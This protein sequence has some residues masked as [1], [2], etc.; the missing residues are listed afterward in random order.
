M[1]VV[2]SS[3][4]TTFLKSFNFCRNRLRAP[5]VDIRTVPSACTS[6]SSWAIS[7]SVRTSRAAPLMFLSNIHMEATQVVAM[8]MRE[9]LYLGSLLHSYPARFFVARGQLAQRSRLPLL[10]RIEKKLVVNAFCTFA[11]HLDGCTPRQ[12]LRQQNYVVKLSFYS[13]KTPISETRQ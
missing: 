4:I 7:S 10:T 9:V 5:I 2:F 11:R 6:E 12:I 1:E 3:S 13:S 8:K